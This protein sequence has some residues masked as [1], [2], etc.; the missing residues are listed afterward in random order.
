MAPQGMVVWGRGWAVLTL[1]PQ[2]YWVC[3]GPLVAELGPVAP[4][5]HEPHFE[6]ARPVPE[7][8]R[9]HEPGHVLAC[10]HRQALVVAAVLLAAVLVVDVEATSEEGMAMAALQHLQA[11]WQHGHAP[12]ELEQHHGGGWLYHKRYRMHRD[13]CMY[14]AQAQVYLLDK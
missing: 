11:Y 5:H 10:A 8:Q 13:A 14:L 2:E 6:A 3:L 1:Q 7:P 9:R 4:P 12:S